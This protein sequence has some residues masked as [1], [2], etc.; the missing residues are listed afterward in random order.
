MK[1]YIGTTYLTREDACKALLDFATFYDILL[2]FGSHN[3][4]CNLSLSP[5]H[6]WLAKQKEQ[7]IVETEQNILL[8]EILKASLMLS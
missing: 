1:N 5:T 2:K 4:G 6:E 8:A 7:Y 3:D